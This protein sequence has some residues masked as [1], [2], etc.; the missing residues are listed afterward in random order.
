MVFLI[1][2]GR[3]QVGIISIANF[4]EFDDFKIKHEVYKFL[5][6]RK[7]ISCFKVPL[8]SYLGEL[9]HIW[10]PKKSE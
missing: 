7:K 1:S 6:N 3:I 9:K 4:S 8:S 10:I 2:C 5:N